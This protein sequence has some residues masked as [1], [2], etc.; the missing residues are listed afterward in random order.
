MI[1]CGLRKAKLKLQH[2][3]QLISDMQTPSHL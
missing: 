2:L 3:Y 1:E